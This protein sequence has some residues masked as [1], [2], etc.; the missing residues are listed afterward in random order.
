MFSLFSD[1]LF[2]FCQ[3]QDHSIQ[4]SYDELPGLL[5]ILIFFN[6]NYFNLAVCHP[7]RI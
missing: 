2:Y 5:N 7:S 6:F 3:I 1:S 4:Y